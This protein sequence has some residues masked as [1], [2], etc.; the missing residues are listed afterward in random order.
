MLEWFERLMLLRVSFADL[1]VVQHA[2]VRLR[3]SISKPMP[4]GIKKF[5]LN[6]KRLSE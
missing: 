6:Y 3:Q 5:F 4:V 2:G 1:W